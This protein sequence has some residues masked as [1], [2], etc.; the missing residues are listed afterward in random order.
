[1][2]RNYPTSIDTLTNPATGDTLASPSH[3]GQH[4]DLNDSVEAIET[5]LGIG[6]SAA[7]SATAGQA[8]ISAGSGTTAWTTIGTANVSSGTAAS[9]TP[10][11]ANGSGGLGY[12]IT[13]MG[14]RYVLTGDVANSNA[15]ANTLA[16]ITGLTHAVVSGTSYYFKAVI[17]Y[18]SAATT[19][20]ARFTVN[21]PTMTALGFRSEYTLTA[22]TTTLNSHLDT[23]QLP[24][25]SNA[26][27]LLVGNIA[28]IEGMFTPSANGTFAIQFA[29]E[30]SSSAITAKAGS[31]LHIY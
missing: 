20:G 16:D 2:P 28:Y 11:I 19:T 29:S 31:F 24:A 5:K 23:R 26:S 30:V 3:A 9:D 7:T 10:L 4:S 8:L 6:A 18:T 12:T 1:M 27:A 25:A 14:T 17:L 21:G 22:T 13:K 15:V